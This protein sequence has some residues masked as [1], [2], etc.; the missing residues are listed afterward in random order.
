MLRCC[1]AAVLQ[2]K[3]PNEKGPRE[4]PLIRKGFGISFYLFRLSAPA[5]SLGCLEGIELFGLPIAVS[6][7]DVSRQATG[8]PVDPLEGGLAIGRTI[9]AVG[10][11]DNST[12]P[13]AAIDDGMTCAPVIRA[14]SLGHEDALRAYLYGLT[15]H[16]YLLPSLF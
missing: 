7:L 2:S 9:E 13:V 16:G 11:F 3:G 14:P 10:I 12:A 15:N 5:L 8:G 6:F 4:G 1:R